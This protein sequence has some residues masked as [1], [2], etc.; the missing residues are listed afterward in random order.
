MASLLSR[1]LEVFVLVVI[2]IIAATITSIACSVTN[3]NIFAASYFECVTLL[4]TPNR[5]YKYEHN[6]ITFSDGD[7]DNIEVY[8]T[9][10]CDSATFGSQVKCA[11]S[12]FTPTQIPCVPPASNCVRWS[13]LIINKFANCGVFSC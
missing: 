4:G 8:G 10:S 6:Q 2:F 1:V 5:I 13:Q 3:R 12:F 9:G 11:P 7:Y